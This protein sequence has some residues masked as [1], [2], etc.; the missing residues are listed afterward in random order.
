MLWKRRLRRER[1][2]EREEALK[3]QRKKVKQKEGMVGNFRRGEEESDA[4]GR[5]GWYF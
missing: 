1:R 4:K 3:E 2:Y 5:N